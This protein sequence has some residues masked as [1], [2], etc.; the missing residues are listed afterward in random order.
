[1]SANRFF[2]CA[3]SFPL[4]SDYTPLPLSLPSFVSY[5][6]LALVPS[7]LP[8]SHFPLPFSLPFAPSEDDSPPICLSL[9]PLPQLLHTK[10]NALILQVLSLTSRENTILL[11]KIFFPFR[12]PHLYGEIGRPEIQLT[13]SLTTIYCFLLISVT[14]ET[15]S[16]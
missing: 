4:F 11:F 15:V 8:S 14:L 2:I 10:S 3:Y 9:Q 16:V 7:F 6:L 13:F 12:R 1:M 5:F